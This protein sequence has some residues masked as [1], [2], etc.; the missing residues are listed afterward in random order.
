MAKQ[1]APVYETHYQLGEPVTACHRRVATLAA[2]RAASA[3]ALSAV[4]AKHTNP[5]DTVPAVPKGQTT[6]Q[7]HAVTCPSC[8]GYQWWYK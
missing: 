7:W 2:V 3:R 5:L 4:P 8:L 6:R 1:P